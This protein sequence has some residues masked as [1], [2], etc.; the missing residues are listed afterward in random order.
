MVTEVQMV[1]HIHKTTVTLTT[2]ASLSL[3]LRSSKFEVECLHHISFNGHC[4]QQYKACRLLG[5]ATLKYHLEGTVDLLTGF[6]VLTLILLFYLFVHL[7]YSIKLYANVLTAG[8]SLV[9]T[10]VHFN[11]VFLISVMPVHD[12]CTSIYCLYSLFSSSSRLRFWYCFTLPSFH[13]SSFRVMFLDLP[14]RRFSALIKSFFC[15]P[16]PFIQKS[17]VHAVQ[18][19]LTCMCAKVVSTYIT[20]FLWNYKVSWNAAERKK[21]FF[22]DFIFPRVPV[23][24]CNH[25]IFK[26]HLSTGSLTFPFWNF[27]NL[28]CQPPIKSVYNRS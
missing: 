11:A 6:L 19:I 28:S 7:C 24:N 20:T 26:R 4:L 23:S 17:H 21:M 12:I 10:Q 15:P 14:V 22:L 8:H 2:N 25:V 27:T 13:L 9:T 1:R 16:C 3:L 5:G 18:Y